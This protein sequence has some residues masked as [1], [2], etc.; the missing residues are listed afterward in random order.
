[1][2]TSSKYGRSC[3][4]YYQFIHV[5][6]DDYSIWLPIGIIPVRL[7]NI[8]ANTWSRQSYKLILI[9]FPVSM[10]MTTALIYGVSGSFF[11]LLVFLLVMMGLTNCNWSCR[12]VNKSNCTQF[13]QLW[14]SFLIPPYSTS[15]I[16]PDICAFLAHHYFYLLQLLL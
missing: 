3:V 16:K 2:K 9:L 11:F 15:D 13:Q 8:I 5:L 6:F 12:W 1:M 7:H 10:S 14:S 4:L